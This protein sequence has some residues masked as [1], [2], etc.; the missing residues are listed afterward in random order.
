MS[1]FRFGVLNMCP[2]WSIVVLNLNT[3]SPV[4]V[5]FRDSLKWHEPLKSIFTLIVTYDVEKVV[6]NCLESLRCLQLM[7]Q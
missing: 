6:V 3:L 1:N 2:V 5:V 4:C 7:L